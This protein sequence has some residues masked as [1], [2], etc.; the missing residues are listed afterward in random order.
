MWSEHIFIFFHIFATNFK[1]LPRQDQKIFAFIFPTI[2][3]IPLIFK[4]SL[5]SLIR[6]YSCSYGLNA[7]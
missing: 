2:C 7:I 4:I 3:W 5:K 1:I 6:N